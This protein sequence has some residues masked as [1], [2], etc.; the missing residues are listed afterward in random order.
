MANRPPFEIEEWY[1]CF[2]RGVEKRKV[3]EDENDAKR[4]L[5]LLYL[6]NGTAPIEIFND[7][8]PSLKKVFETDRGDPVVGVGAFCLMPN[9][10]H[11]LLKETTEGGISS[12]MKKV[13][14]AYVMYF[15]AKNERV[16]NLFIKPFRSR[17]IATDSYF[18]HVLQYIHCNPAELYEPGWKEGKV[19]SMRS[20]ENKLLNYPYS[21]FASYGERKAI[22]PI[23]SAD[24][25]DVAN[26]LPVSRMLEDAR[27]YYAQVAQER[28]E[29]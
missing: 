16:G 26:Q 17:H 5:M 19:R 29:K 2:N 14:I 12:F 27:S 10:F 15:N 22:S 1:H 3:F 20:L 24:G 11:L 6:A 4:F 13:G 21:S 18:Q 7:P 8:K 9:H 25:F 28:F 23:L